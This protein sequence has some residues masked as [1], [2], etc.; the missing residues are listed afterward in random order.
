MI[1]VL[2]TA[3]GSELAFSIIKAIKL[4][5][6]PV[7]LIGCDIYPEVV[8]KYWCDSFHIVPPAKEEEDF[9]TCLGELVAERAI[10]VIIPTNDIEFFVLAK[11][12]EHFL[13]TLNCH[14]LVNAPSEIERFNDKWRA[15]QWYQTK[16]LAAPQTFLAEEV[17]ALRQQLLNMSYPLIVKPRRG[18]GSREI[19]K[20]DGFEELVNCLPLVTRPIVQEYLSGDDAE[21]TAGTY[22]TM[23][24]EVFVIVM[25]RTLKFGMTNTAQTVRDAGLES[26]CREIILNTDLVGA[27]NIQFRVTRDGPRILEIN[28]RFSGTTGI[29]ARFGFN[30]VAMW[31]DEQVLNKA[32]SAPRVREGHVMRYMQEQY[33]FLN[34]DE[35]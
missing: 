15:Y 11:Y 27:N 31:I 18:G 8:G 33:H 24:N 22:R 13:Q 9:I 2:V 21:Y 7:G 14:I 4:I 29:R 25:K 26:F 32:P 28:P 17:E 5:A 10:D 3:V 16:Q 6:P 12:K 20:V 1:N 23:T 34:S 30:E 35:A 19:F